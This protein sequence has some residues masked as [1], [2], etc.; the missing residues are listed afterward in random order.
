MNDLQ[1]VPY[2]DSTVVRPVLKSLNSRSVEWGAPGGMLVD[3]D[4]N[5]ESLG[6]IVNLC[7]WSIPAAVVNQGEEIVLARIIGRC[8]RSGYD[9]TFLSN[10]WN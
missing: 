7:V 1:I 8:E 9:Q 3:T 6:A 4:L 10:V 2:C 5:V